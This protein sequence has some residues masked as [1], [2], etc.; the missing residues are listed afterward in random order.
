MIRHGKAQ[1][2]SNA[3]RRKVRAHQS[4]N[5]HQHSGNSKYNCHPAVVRYM[6]GVF[7]LRCDFDDLPQN[8]PDIPERYQRQQRTGGGQH[9]RKVGQDFVAPGI[10]QQPG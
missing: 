1:I 5:I 7:I 3:E 4:R 8:A 10:L 9:P 6:D 2:R